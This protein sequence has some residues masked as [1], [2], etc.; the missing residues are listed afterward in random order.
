MDTVKTN[1][2]F[3]CDMCNKFINEGGKYCIACTRY[4]Y[5]RTHKCPDCDYKMSEY[6]LNRYKR[7]YMCNVKHNKRDY[8][9]YL[10]INEN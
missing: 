4:I 10:F 9:Q 8:K 6:S 5:H 3:F 1:H 2:E 7:C